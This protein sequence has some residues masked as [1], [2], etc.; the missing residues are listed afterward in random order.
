[1]YIS[2]SFWNCNKEIDYLNIIEQNRISFLSFDFLSFLYLFSCPGSLVC[3][4]CTRFNWWNAHW[5]TWSMN[6]SFLCLVTVLLFLLCRV[7]SLFLS[8]H[9]S[10]L[11][12]LLINMAPCHTPICHISWTGVCLCCLSF[13]SLFQCLFASSDML[14]LDF[15]PPLH[16]VSFVE[17]H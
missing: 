10:H 16:L 14:L 3:R 13:T 11:P 4:C 2:W 5:H 15:P 12:L 17:W 9:C 1:M 6:V 8:L 7:L